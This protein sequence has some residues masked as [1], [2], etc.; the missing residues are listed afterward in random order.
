[1]GFVLR[2]GF[3]LVNGNC[4]RVRCDA[5][6]HGR[7]LRDADN[8]RAAGLSSEAWQRKRR[9]FLIKDESGKM[10]DEGWFP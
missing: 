6:A 4:L 1:M 7:D 9:S 2:G 5:F 3:Y 8:V 10:K